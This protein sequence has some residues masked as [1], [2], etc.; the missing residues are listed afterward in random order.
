MKKILFIEDENNLNEAYRIKF[1]SDYEV[2]FAV[3]ATIGLQKAKEWQP[4]LIILDI[5]MAGEMNGIGVLKELKSKSE[6]VA[7]PVIIL[8]NLEDQEETVKQMGAIACLL[9]ANTSFEVLAQK[10]SE[11]IQG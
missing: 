1:A 8:T 6:T 3:D 7:I 9:K 11:V 10:I 4:D 2:D 5:I